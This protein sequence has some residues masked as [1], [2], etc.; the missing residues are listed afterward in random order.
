MPRNNYSQMEIP[1]FLYGTAWKEDDTERCVLAA[2]RSGFRA[3][4]TANQRK[5]YYEEGAGRGIAQAMKELGLKREDIFIQTKFTYARG[6]DQ[7]L[8]YNPGV[9][10][11]MQVH[12]SFASS[13]T[14]LQTNY[15]DSYVL[16]GPS[17]NYGL[18]QDDWQT[19]SAMEALFSQ[20]HVKALGIS[21]VDLEQLSMLFER[22]EIKPQYVQN[23]C[24]AEMGWDK[25]VRE[26]CVENGIVYQGF[27]LLTANWRFLGGEIIHPE[28][29]TLRQLQLGQSTEAASHLH[30]SV[31]AILAAT[32]KSISQ[33]VFRFCQQVGMLPLTGTQSVE[34]MR[35]DLSISDFTLS[36]DQ[37]EI[38]ENIAFLD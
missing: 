31:R 3:I 5:H 33:V 35:A 38:L 37:L 34:N 32:G 19:W 1:T 28:G 8:P 2:L 25:Q 12:Q 29:R 18:S 7:R 15:L 14:H 9:P 16:H 10:F 23:R 21:N 22:A 36:D 27:S 24:Y 17:G 20:G 13:L 6:Q 26:F 4:D 30:P 11:S